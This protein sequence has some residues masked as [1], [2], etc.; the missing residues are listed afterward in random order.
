[1]NLVHRTRSGGLRW[2][3]VR[4]LRLRAAF[5]LVFLPAGLGCG[6]QAPSG[7]PSNASDGS[8]ETG[9]DASTTGAND[10]GADVAA[11]PEAGA[12]SDATLDAGP[13]PT[14]DA[15]LSLD[16]EAGLALDT[17]IETGGGSTLD[18][19]SSEAA[20]PPGDASAD[21]LPGVCNFS[22]CPL[23]CC[24]TSGH[25]QSGSP[26][27][28]GTGGSACA[29]CPS[30]TECLYNEECVCT[31]NSCPSGCC[32]A[33]PGRLAQLAPDAGPFCVA[34][35]SDTSCGLAGADCADC[36][37][38]GQGASCVGQKC[39]SLP[40]CTCTSGCCDPQGHCHPGSLDT[41]CGGSNNSG[42]YCVD[43]TTSGWVCS[44]QMC[45]PP[46]ATAC[47]ATTCPTGCCD[48]NDQCQPGASSLACGSAGANCQVCL[49]G[50]VCDNQECVTAD[51]GALCNGNNCHGCCDATGVCRSGG[52][53]TACGVNGILCADCTHVGGQCSYG[54]CAGFDA[55]SSCMEFCIGCCDTSGVCHPGTT[56][57]QCGFQACADCTATNPPSTC[58]VN[59]APRACASLQC[60]LPY[61]SCPAPLQEQIPVRQMV[62]STTEL[63]AAA[64]ACADGPNSAACAAFATSEGNTN[65]PCAQCLQNFEVSFADETGILYCA[66]PYVDAACNHSS[67]CL[68]DCLATTCYECADPVSLAQCQTQAQTGACA[69]YFHDAC[70]AQALNG[71]GAVC[72]PASYATFGA[73]LQA[74]GSA[75]CGP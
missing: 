10:A 60:P 1:M 36:T 74:V 8:A 2:L 51:G 28:C 47:N 26:S 58:N 59:A 33:Q 27:F 3:A 9:S 50:G 63:Q 54:L 22:N 32:A 16:A 71:A 15:N 29:T 41:Q 39:V 64:T 24:D 56:D 19:H 68:N 46:P 23:G 52:D 6:G 4:A 18:A 43:C 61:P 57:T 66:A 65:G 53:V 40:W 20:A 75:Y 67:A 72:N 14:V 11:N 5:A 70:I 31:A 34:G 21:A 48:Q 25:C 73:W 38:Q 45:T 17:G 7:G 35:T 13:S 42:S 49:P 69:A 37:G 44:Q 62:C 30:G 55:A 12:G